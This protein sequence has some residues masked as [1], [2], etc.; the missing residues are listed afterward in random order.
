VKRKA[1]TARPDSERCEADRQPLPDGTAARCRKPRKNGSRY[2][3]QHDRI[4]YGWKASQAALA[5][6]QS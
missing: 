4:I 6:M 5:G 1:Y 3:A 2:C